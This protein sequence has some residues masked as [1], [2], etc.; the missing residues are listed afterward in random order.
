MAA[1]PSPRPVRPRPS[2]VVP[3]TLTGAPDSA[4]DRTFSA[5]A[6]RGAILGRLPMT[7]TAT[8][9]TVKPASVTSRN[10]SRSR[11]T[12]RAPAHSGRDVPNCAPRS[13]RPAADRRASQIAWA[14]TSPSEWPVSPASPSQVRPARLSVRSAPN[15]CTSVPTPTRGNGY[16]PP[17]SVI[18][19]CPI[20]S[21]KNSRPGPGAECTGAI[22]A[23]GKE[24]SPG[25][26][27]GSGAEHVPQADFREMTPGPDRYVLTTP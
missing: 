16:R 8:L 1:M 7:W 15:G 13:P 20:R 23:A 18:N 26:Q 21:W 2:V 24:L 3:D 25:T 14:A 5:S 11:T 22:M 17:A 12:P 19:G 10:V 9:P 4:S 27:S 6:R